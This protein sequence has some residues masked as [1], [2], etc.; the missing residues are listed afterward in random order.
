MKTYSTREEWLVAAGQALDKKF[1]KSNGFDLPAYRVSCGWAKG[2]ARAIGQCFGKA[3]SADEHFEIFVCPTQADPMVVVATLLHELIHAAVGTHEG[4]KGP[5]RT[6]AKAF[7]FA[8]KMTS[9][10]AETGTELHT[11]LA[12]LHGRL[13]DYPH[14]IMSKKQIDRKPTKWTRYKSTVEEDYKVVANIDKV[15]EHGVPRDPWGEEMVPN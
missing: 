14:A 5:F 8:G 6:V 7:G 13:G 9:T 2:N 12:T 4:H 11:T 15:G 1:F 3:H 10:F